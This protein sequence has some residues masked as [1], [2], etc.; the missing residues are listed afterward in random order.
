VPPP[1]KTPPVCPIER[2]IVVLSG[3][4]KAMILWHLFARPRRYTDLA[5]AIPAVSQRALTQALRELEADG[6]VRRDGPH[7]TVT[8]LGAD[9]RPAL[10]AMM[11]WGEAQRDWIDARAARAAE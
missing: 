9:L 1:R 11:E 5:R 8:A 10:A 2:T 6:V 3:R 7:W 4:W